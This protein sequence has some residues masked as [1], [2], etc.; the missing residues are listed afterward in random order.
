[1]IR[2]KQEKRNRALWK[3]IGERL[4]LDTAT[5]H[6]GGGIFSLVLLPQSSPKAFCEF[7]FTTKP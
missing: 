5:R 2:E 7:R 4:E 1:M 3:I 6:F